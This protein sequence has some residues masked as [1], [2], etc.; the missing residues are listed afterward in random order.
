MDT[1]KLDELVEFVKTKLIKL[2]D[3]E[4]NNLIL[5]IQPNNKTGG[6]KYKYGKK[7][8]MKKNKK[9]KKIKG[10]F[11]TAFKYFIY[12]ILRIIFR[13]KVTQDI[14]TINDEYSNVELNDNDV[15]NITKD[16]INIYMSTA[17]II[18]FGMMMIQFLRNT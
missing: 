1:Q 14:S 8:T 11:N 12:N 18:V 15:S 7:Y 9:I 16:D 2:N 5:K 3:V 17:C 10:G 13:L 4:F 6:K